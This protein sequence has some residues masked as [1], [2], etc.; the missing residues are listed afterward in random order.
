MQEEKATAVHRYLYEVTATRETHNTSIVQSNPVSPLPAS[1]ASRNEE[2][3]ERSEDFPP[4]GPPL[5]AVKI[6]P[7]NP[8]P[9]QKKEKKSQPPRQR[10]HC[11]GN[12]CPS[13]IF[14]LNEILNLSPFPYKNHPPPPPPSHSQRLLPRSSDLP[15]CTLRSL[16][17]LPLA[18]WRS[19]G[20][21]RS[22]RP[23]A[24]PT[25]AEVG[26]PLPASPS[27]SRSPAL[28]ARSPPEAG[29]PSR[30]A[31]G[32]LAWSHRCRLV[33]CAWAGR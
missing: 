1:P 13:Q 4:R 24:V 31:T 11:P 23:L 9:L 2:V 29:F 32:A 5:L 15:A 17:P 10:R 6:P 16:L 3:N 8:L 7:S 19:T 30:G 25:L 18:T 27:R 14:L 22:R 12:R 21:S 33:G 20:I 26:P 28:L